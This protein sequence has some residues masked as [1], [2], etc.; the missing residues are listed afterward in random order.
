MRSHHLIHDNPL[1]ILFK[2]IFDDKHVICLGRQH[3]IFS[4]MSGH[5]RW[6]RNWVPRYFDLKTPIFYH[7]FLKKH[8]IILNC[9]ICKVKTPKIGVKSQNQIK[10]KKPL[11]SLKLFF[12]IKIKVSNH[13]HVTLFSKKSP[14]TL[15]FFSSRNI[16][17]QKLLSPLS[18]MI[19]SLLSLWIYGLKSNENKIQNWSVK[20][21]NIGTNSLK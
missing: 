1:Q 9:P 16:V 3:V 12:S 20:N 15:D 18:F 10:Y 6:P 7:L 8:N 11:S 19:T 17:G 2:K 13:F 5:L 21:K 4:T 14:L